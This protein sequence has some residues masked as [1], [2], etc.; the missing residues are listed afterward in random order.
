[1]PRDLPMKALLLVCLVM[2]ACGPGRDAAPPA[3][4]EKAANGEL[5]PAGA[6]HPGTIV[7]NDKTDGRV[8][9]KRAAEVPQTIA[10]VEAGAEWVPVVRIETSG[11]PG[12]R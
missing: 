12:P 8:W 1:M 5:S 11:A 2:G 3:R 9:T 6:R 7:F 10:W 4:S